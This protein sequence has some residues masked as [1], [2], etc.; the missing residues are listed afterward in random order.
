MYGVRIPLKYSSGSRT[1]RPTPKEEKQCTIV[2]RFFY[3]GP[4]SEAKNYQLWKSY[5]Q[6][7][8]KTIF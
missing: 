1:S 6:N 2:P 5:T 8:Y 7:Y 3:L 4:E